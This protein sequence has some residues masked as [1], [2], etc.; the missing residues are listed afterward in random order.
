[1]TRQVREILK[2]RLDVGLSN[3]IIAKQLGVGETSVRDTLKRM[4]REGLTWPL[5]DTISD[6]ELEQRLYGAPGKKAGRR[7]Q[8]EPDWSAVAR[9]LKRKH[10]TLQVLWEEHIARDPAGYRYSRFCELFRNW[11]GRLPLVM[12]GLCTGA[13]V[14]R[15]WRMGVF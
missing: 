3:R 7:K 8:S 13:E 1:M 11:Q 9:E 12:G 6:R 14:W 10:V 15:R 5:P 4:Q 2:L